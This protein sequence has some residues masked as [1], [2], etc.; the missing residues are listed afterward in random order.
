MCK[1]VIGRHFESSTCARRL[2]GSKPL[3]AISQWYAS[4]S[5]ASIV[6]GMLCID[7]HVLRPCSHWTHGPQTCQSTL[8]SQVEFCLSSN[9]TQQRE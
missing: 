1:A 5:T 9:K 8:G 6:Q 4:S 7:T 3:K 2:E